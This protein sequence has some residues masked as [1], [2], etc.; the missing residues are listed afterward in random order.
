MS[1]P[2]KQLLDEMRQ[3]LQRIEHNYR[4]IVAD[5]LP[6]ATQQDERAREWLA[7]RDRENPRRWTAT[8]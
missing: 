4:R 7:E 5:Q 8:G 6:S 2:I 1:D 3:Q